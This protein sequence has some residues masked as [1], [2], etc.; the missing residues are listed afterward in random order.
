MV[1]TAP[2]WA[3]VVLLATTAGC[4]MCASPYD[5]CGPVLTGDAC[6]PCAPG[7]RACS[8]LAPGGQVCC[9]SQVPPGTIVPIPD[10]QMVGPVPSVEQSVEMIATQPHRQATAPP[11]RFR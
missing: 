7:A 2:A 1:R 5:Y 10:S 9:D 11:S 6:G 3:V 4:R 8:I